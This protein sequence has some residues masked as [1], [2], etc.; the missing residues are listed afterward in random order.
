[1]K[2]DLIFPPPWNGFAGPYL[3]LGELAA[4]LRPCGVDLRL[5][6]ANILTLRHLLRPESV[7]RAAEAARRELAKNASAPRKLRKLQTAVALTPLILE[8]LED[9]CA[10]FDKGCFDLRQSSFYYHVLEIAARIHSALTFPYGFRVEDARY[11]APR[12]VLSR[13]GPQVKAGRGERGPF[14]EAFRTRVLPRLRHRQGVPIG[15]SVPF[16]GQI[17]PALRLAH[18][19]KQEEPQAIVVCG[20][21]AWIY[22]LHAL[23]EVP[24]IFDL[25][26]FIVVLEGEYPLLELLSGKSPDSIPNLFWRSKEGKVRGR[27]TSRQLRTEEFLTPDFEGL[28]LSLYMNARPVLPYLMGRGCYYSRCAFCSQASSYGGG[29]RV[30]PVERIV[31]DLA[32]YDVRYGAR[33]V[34]FTDEALPPDLLRRVSHEILK[35]GLDVSWYGLVRCEK[36]FREEDFRLFRKAGCRLLS[37]GVESGSQQL[38]NRMNKRVSLEVAERVIGWAHDAEIWVNNFFIFG[39][40]GETK[41]DVRKTLRFLHRL[42][43]SIDSVSFGRFILER[44]SPIYRQPEAYGIRIVA[45]LSDTISEEKWELLEGEPWIAPGVLSQQLTQ[46]LKRYSFHPIHNHLISNILQVLRQFPPAAIRALHEERALEFMRARA[47][48]E[49]DGNIPLIWSPDIL[50]SGSTETLSDGVERLRCRVGIRPSNS[51]VVVIV[52]EEV[53]R[54]FQDLMTLTSF[55]RALQHQ[56]SLG[57]AEEALKLVRELIQTHFLVPHSSLAAA[58]QDDEVQPL[59]DAVPEP[60]RLQ[61]LRD[62]GLPSISPAKGMRIQKLGLYKP[63]SGTFR[64]VGCNDA[65]VILKKGYVREA[66]LQS[67]LQEILPQHVPRVL[68][69]EVLPDEH[70]PGGPRAVLL[71]QDLGAANDCPDLVQRVAVEPEDRSSAELYFEVMGWAAK[72]LAAVH[73]LFW[74]RSDLLKETLQLPC[75][76]D[77][78]GGSV[79]EVIERLP[80]LW[81]A[82]EFDLYR[83]F[84]PVVRKAGLQ[85]DRAA[86]QLRTLPETLLHYDF[87]VQNVFWKATRPTEIW[88]LDWGKARRGP[89]ALDLVFLDPLTLEAHLMALTESLAQP[90]PRRQWD[91]ALRAAGVIRRLEILVHTLEAERRGIDLQV[92]P[93][94]IHNTNLSAL[95]G[96]LG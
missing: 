63:Q 70:G 21:P 69:A 57:V 81:S 82:V 96:C 60:R 86:A 38:V 33:D 37:F 32:R 93:S 18:L 50:W 9:A 20:G 66:R 26:D 41:E 35:R 71:L 59:L 89:A 54:T 14:E 28:D 73:A 30:R 11:T 4:F 61:A 29:Y 88:L 80:E 1:V 58:V 87:Q 64:L 74:N 76:L 40:P 75:A 13:L 2:L 79:F 16:F 51:D 46:R 36:G 5:H 42:R 84:D 47:S 77:E 62:A 12:S 83:R 8:H 85:V 27:T 72:V 95:E 65:S 92:P 49:S 31:D 43:G 44:F 91:E 56:G 52:P 68:T 78:T 55:E 7:Q 23:P 22:A 3:A 15:I 94:V 53:H 6:D 39:F 19:I 67:V 34:E 25:F 17:I 48:L 45:A 10:Y 24:E 90:P